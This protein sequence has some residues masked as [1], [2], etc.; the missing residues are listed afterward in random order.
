[1]LADQLY[2]RSLS[3]SNFAQ[4]PQER[5]RTEL[6]EFVAKRLIHRQS[7]PL[8]RSFTSTTA[9]DFWGAQATSPADRG[10]L[11]RLLCVHHSE[12][13]KRLAARAPQ[14]GKFRAAQRERRATVLDQSQRPQDSNEAASV[15]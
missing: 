4:F 14:T 10:S 3:R 12:Q 7:G 6:I 5:T 13:R 8:S 15:Q 2:A 11:P 1:M 9:A